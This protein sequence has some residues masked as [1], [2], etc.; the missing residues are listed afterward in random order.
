MKKRKKDAP[1]E[2]VETPSFTDP[3]GSWTGVPRGILADG[4][5]VFKGMKSGDVDPRAQVENCYTAS[6]KAIA[7]GGGV[8]Q[9]IL[10]YTGVLRGVAGRNALEV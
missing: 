1:V 4:T 7:I 5:P 2:R 3:Q 6:D 8:L 9:A 10:E